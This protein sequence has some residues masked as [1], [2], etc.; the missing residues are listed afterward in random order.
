MEKDFIHFFGSTGD[1][2]V[3]FSNKRS[4]GGVY[5]CIDGVKVIL[6][7]G[8][9]TFNKFV[10]Q[11]PD[12]I[13]TIDALVLS[14][15]HFDHSNDFNIFIEGMTNGGECKRGI[16]LAPRQALY[17]EDCIINN[18][19][20][21][22][23]EKII[24]VEPETEYKVN[25]IKI[26]SSTPHRHGT[27]NYGYTFY[28]ENHVITFITDTVYFDGLAESYPRS[29]ILVVN[30]PYASVPNGKKMKHLSLDSIPYI[31]SC[32]KPQKVFLTHFGESMINAGPEKCA[33]ALSGKVSCDVLA[34]EDNK[35]YILS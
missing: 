18:Y 35:K 17:G 11:Y 2:A 27:E 13:S 19:L 34:V 24:E 25:N 30:V 16:A 12:M 28:S 15:V 20:R 1:K 3:I 5:I 14:H 26:K 21:S 7:P 22:F 33:K 8:P 10:S 4:T 6:D 31:I 29:D 32:L 9:G 23:P